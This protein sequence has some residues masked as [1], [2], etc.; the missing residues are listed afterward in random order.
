M[1]LFKYFISAFC[2]IKINT[3][4][5]YIF[6]T[7]NNLFAVNYVLRNMPEGKFKYSNKLYFNKVYLIDKDD[8]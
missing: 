7:N 3:S 1:S 5:L 4:C 8:I 6:L 2:N